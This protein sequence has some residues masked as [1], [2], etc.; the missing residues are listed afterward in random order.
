MDI[1]SRQHEA[2]VGL[3]FAS[4]PPE[5]RATDVKELNQFEN[6]FSQCAGSI[7]TLFREKTVPNFV[8]TLDQNHSNEW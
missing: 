3:G 5:L 4:M 7:G 2:K 8:P 1:E 6:F